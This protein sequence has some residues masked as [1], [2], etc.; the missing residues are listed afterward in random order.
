MSNLQGVNNKKRVVKVRDEMVAH[1]S[2][3]VAAV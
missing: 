3:A 1:K 2:E